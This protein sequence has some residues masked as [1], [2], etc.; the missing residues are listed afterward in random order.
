MAI[1]VILLIL[2]SELVNKNVFD[3]LWEFNFPIFKSLSSYLSQQLLKRSDS[4]N[5]KLIN[6]ITLLIWLGVRQVVLAI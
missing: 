6:N 5:I 3:R 2:K 1:N 4:K